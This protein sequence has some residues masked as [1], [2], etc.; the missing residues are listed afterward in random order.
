MPV[1]SYTLVNDNNNNIF[2]T[3]VIKFYEKDI[4]KMTK[5][6]ANYQ[7]IGN[8]KIKNN[9][10]SSYDY[11]LNKKYKIKIN[12]KTLERVKNYFR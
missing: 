11:F 9:I 2:L 7:N 6:F 1:N 5:D 12:E 4:S 8:L 10:F 3:K